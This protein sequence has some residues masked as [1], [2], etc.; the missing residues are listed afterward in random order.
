MK[1]ARWE[2]TR[3]EGIKDVKGKEVSRRDMKEARRE[4]NTGRAEGNKER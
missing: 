4:G 3:R 1:E 2:E